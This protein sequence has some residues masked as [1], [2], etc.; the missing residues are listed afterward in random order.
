MLVV[1]VACSSAGSASEGTAVAYSATNVTMQS[2]LLLYHDPTYAFD[3]EF[4]R[5]WY[6]GQTS[7]SGYGIVAASSNDPA[8]SRAAISVA[9]E[10][11]T[12]TLDLRQ[13]AMRAEATLGQQAG[14]AAFTIEDSHPATVNGLPAQERTYSYTLNQHKVRQRSVY[15][16]R[17]HEL[18]DLSLITPQELYS[19]YD[20]LFSNI[21]ATFKGASS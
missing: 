10:P 14:I 13:A 19:Q 4:P 11:V 3:M 16:S 9:V 7:S 17:Q 12:G 5:S 18:Y 1:L 6:I 21:V 15:L 8:Q 2:D 20:Q